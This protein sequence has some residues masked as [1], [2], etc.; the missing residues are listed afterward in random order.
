[1]AHKSYDVHRMVVN[2][3]ERSKIVTLHDTHEREL[4]PSMILRNEL[5][6]HWANQRRHCHRRDLRFL[7]RPI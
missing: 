5:F 1:M 6:V 2:K 7:S 3:K 4:G